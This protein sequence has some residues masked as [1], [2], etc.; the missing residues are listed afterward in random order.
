MLYYDKIDISKGIDDNETND[1]HKCIICN[2][3]YF[4]KVNFRFKPK[5]W[6]LSWVYAKSCEF[7]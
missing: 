6:W 5:V 4:L 2:Y 1:S 7:L 3:Y